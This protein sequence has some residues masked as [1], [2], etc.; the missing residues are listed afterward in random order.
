MSFLDSIVRAVGRKPPAPKRPD[1]E[2]MGDVLV[3][4]FLFDHF[5]L[6]DE[7][8]SRL[9]ANV[10]SELRL[11]AKLWIVIYGSWL[12]R[13]ALREAYGTPFM[14]A[15]LVAARRRLAR[16]VDGLDGA[17]FM[18]NLDFSLAAIDRAANIPGAMTQ[19]AETPLDLLVAWSFLG[20]D[21][22]SPCHG[23]TTF[24][25]GLDLTIAGCLN[26]GKRAVSRFIEIVVEIGGPLPTDTNKRLAVIS[27]AVAA[28]AQRNENALGWSS[29]PGPRE[30]HLRVRDGNPL[31]PVERRLITR[32]DVEAAQA[33]DQHELCT[34]NDDL[35]LALETHEQRQLH[36]LTRTY[37]INA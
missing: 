31:F 28:I 15:A 14:E 8:F 11:Q 7:D 30:R 1:A 22:E 5:G 21:P 20:G 27:A 26:N 32:A 18:A 19:G 17:M 37:L 13:F 33:D 9:T 36:T 2:L 23:Q 12:F 25:D 24:P 10:P 29:D 16:K 3:S 6:T 4:N 35:R 34:L